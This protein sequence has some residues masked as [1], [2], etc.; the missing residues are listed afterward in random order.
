MPRP[1]SFIPEEVLDKAMVLFWEKGFE[2]TSV[3]DLVDHMGINRFS[4]YSTFGDKH[5][6]FLKAL[7]RYRDQV[8]RASLSCL[9]SDSGLPA[10]ERFFDSL[11][12]F[13]RA[14]QPVRGCMMVNA[15]V[16]LAPRDA[17]VS[18][19]VRCHRE[20]VEEALLRQVII[21]RQR[22][23]IGAERDPGELAAFLASCA[24]GLGV[25]AK[26]EPGPDT[27]E[28]T[29]RSALLALDTLPVAV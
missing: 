8:V 29:C 24:L 5:T 3:Q 9:E 18:T 14:Q 10:I 21:A 19:R 17:K 13:L 7:D 16:E 4:L 6:L 25:L 1:K 27:L 11:V 2:A 15:A 20:M 12:Q 28:A 23:Q 22:G 26:T